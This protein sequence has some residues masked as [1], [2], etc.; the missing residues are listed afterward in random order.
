MAFLNLI[1]GLSFLLTF[2]SLI[3]L[4]NLSTSLNF[5]I[6]APFAI[7]LVILSL[8]SILEPTYWLLLTATNIFLVTILT[9]AGSYIIK[10]NGN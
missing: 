10:I 7:P 9:M 6:V 4:K 2:S 8:L 5:I 1:V 3:T